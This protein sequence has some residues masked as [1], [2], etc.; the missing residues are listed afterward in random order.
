MVSS[1]R[2]FN[3]P[4]ENAGVFPTQWQQV[5][6]FMCETNVGHM[7]AMALILITWSLTEK[8]GNKL[9]QS[10]SISKH[11]FF[12]SYISQEPDTVNMWI[13]NSAYNIWPIMPNFNTML[14]IQSLIRFIVYFHS[15]MIISLTRN[16]H[17]LCSLRVAVTDLWFGTWILEQMNLT[18]VIGHCHHSLTVRA[19]QGID[20]CP[21]WSLEP[22]T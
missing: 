11:F 12:F 10:C 8:T 6:V 9:L 2:P 19:T 13:I 20:V 7:T 18:E 15:K 16:E 5:N 17:W 4:L 22:H 3:S 1:P 21:I 14:S